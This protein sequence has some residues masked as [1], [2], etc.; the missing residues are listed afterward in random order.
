MLF[1]SFEFL[2]FIPLVI[3]L[4]FLLPVKWRWL[5]LLLA[6]YFFYGFYNPFYIPLLFLSTAIDFIA[7]QKIATA[8][9]AFIKKLWLYVSLA[10]NLGLLFFFKYFNFFSAEATSFIQ[11]FGF[12]YQLPQHNFLLP[13]GISFYTFQTLSYTIDIYRGYLKPE[14][15]FGKFSLYIC[16][17][18]QLVAGPIEKAK[19]LLP[20]FHFNYSFEYQRVVQGLQLILWGFFKKLIIADRLGLYVNEVYLVTNEHHGFPIIL[21]TFF[22]TL[23]IFYDFS[24]YCDIAIGI[25]RILGIK[26]SKNFDNHIYQASPAKFWQNWHITLT[27][28]FRNYVFFPLSQINRKKAFWYFSLLLTF[29]VTGLWHGAAWTFIIWG[30]LH[31]LYLIID[32]LTLE[33]RVSFFSKIGLLQYPQIVKI[34]GIIFT[35]CL[36]M[37]SVVFFRASSIAEALHLMTI[38]FDWSIFY[39]DVGKGKFELVLT[40]LLLIFIDLI[41]FKLGSDTIFQF[42]EQQATWFRWG[43][44]ILLINLILFARVP[45][46]AKF[47]Y[48]EF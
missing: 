40:F 11:F 5:L 24:A 14:P 29:I 46:Q 26:L 12:D 6:S 19:N 4:Y 10:A 8:T 7:G 43:F 28:W 30:T 45:E 37:F 16:F 18:P 31:G 32:Q 17:F 2:L 23:Q 21:A 44:Y 27:E 25:A 39:I 34:L 48:F 15:H 36:L 41:N 47:I 22:F 13:L 35:M 38:A 33:K 3:G 1:V 9:N 20:Q 42:L